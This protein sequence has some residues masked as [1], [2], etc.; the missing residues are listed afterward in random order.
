MKSTISLV[1][2]LVSLVAAIIGLVKSDNSLDQ[3]KRTQEQLATTINQL[4]MINNQ[5]EIDIRDT[6]DDLSRTSTQMKQDLSWTAERL[7]KTNSELSQFKDE[8]KEEIGEIRN[9]LKKVTEAEPP[10]TQPSDTVR[11][12]IQFETPR[13]FACGASLAWSGLITWEPSENPKIC[14]GNYVYSVSGRI[15]PYGGEKL[16]AEIYVH[17]NSIWYPAS[18][19]GLVDPESNGSFSVDF[20]MQSKG[21]PRT[22]RFLLYRNGNVSGSECRVEVM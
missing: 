20:C 1:A 9:V 4:T 18:G 19:G 3:S 11:E 2:A 15:T 17:E 7:D 16:S 6:R 8:T 13:G 12:G 5:I 10:I 21:P 14:L 22:F